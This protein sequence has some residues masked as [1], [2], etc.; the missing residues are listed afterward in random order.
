MESEG[1]FI[2]LWMC[3]GSIDDDPCQSTQF[4]LTKEGFVFCN[5]CGGRQKMT[6]KFGLDETGEA[7]EV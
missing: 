2:E 7:S 5:L 1:E 4:E 3:G 6:W